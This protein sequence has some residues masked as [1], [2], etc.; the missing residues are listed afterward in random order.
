MVIRDARCIAQQS[1]PLKY[2]ERVGGM[3]FGSDYGL[4]KPFGCC[5]LRSGDHPVSRPPAVINLWMRLADL[6]QLVTFLYFADAR[7]VVCCVLGSVFTTPPTWE[8]AAFLAV[9]TGNVPETGSR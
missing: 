6:V 5:D 4:H 3:E 7:L 9:T 1:S 2:L 8:L